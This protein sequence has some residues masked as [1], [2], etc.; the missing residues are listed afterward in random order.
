MLPSVRAQVEFILAK[1]VGEAIAKK[2]CQASNLVLVRGLIDQ[3]KYG[4]TLASQATMYM[5]FWPWRIPAQMTGTTLNAQGFVIHDG[6]APTG[7][8][9]ANSVLLGLYDYRRIRRTATAWAWGKANPRQAVGAILLNRGNTTNAPGTVAAVDIPVRGIGIPWLHPAI[10]G[11]TCSIGIGGVGGASYVHTFASQNGALLAYTFTGHN[12]NCYVRINSGPDAGLYRARTFDGIASPNRIYLSNLDGTHFVAAGGVQTGVSVTVFARVLPY[13]NES[14]GGV[15]PQSQGPV[16]FA[17]SFDPGEN[18]TSYMFRLYYEKSGSPNPA[19][20]AHLKGSYW[21]AVRPYV[22]GGANVTT[23]A[24]DG[25]RG[26]LA[27]SAIGL[28][29]GGLAAGSMSAGFVGGCPGMVLDRT[30]Q[31]L[32]G[33]TDNGTLSS[34]WWWLY[35]TP[36]CL[37][38]AWS[39][40]GTPNDPIAALTGLTGRMRGIDID[41][42]GNVY[43]AL[44]GSASAGI[45][46][47][48]PALAVTRW[49][50]SSLAGATNA[51]NGVKIDKTR[52]RSTAAGTVSTAAGT[53]IQTVTVT[54]GAFTQAD[55]GRAI[56]LSGGSADNGTYKIAAYVSATQVTVSTLAGGNVTFT[57]TSNSG[58]M[59]IGDRIY[60]F[61]NDALAWAGSTTSNIKLAY[62]ETEA[63]GTILQTADCA[64]TASTGRTLYDG[65]ATWRGNAP[66]AAIDP[67][68]GN[69]FWVSS[70]TAQRINR[71]N[72]T[73]RTVS[74]KTVA[75]FTEPADAS[76][77]A[78]PTVCY[79]IG[80]NPH[81]SFREVW[82]ATDVGIIRFSPDH[83]DLSTLTTGAYAYALASNQYRRY[84][85][86]GSST[87]YT[88]PANYAR[89][90][91]C[92][93]SVVGAF[94]GVF[95]GLDGKVYLTH[96][97][98]NGIVQYQ[99]D[100]DFFTR[101]SWQT[102]TAYPGSSSAAQGV[103]ATPYGEVVVMVP[104]VT[105]SV[106]ITIGSMLTDYQWITGA[107]TAK[108]FIRGV[109]PDAT[110]QPEGLCKDLHTTTD[111]LLFG[112]KVA[113]S[114]GIGTDA[115][116]AIGR[117][118][119]K[120]AVQTDGSWS[121]GNFKGSNFTAADVGR[122]LRVE[123]GA[124][125]GIYRVTAYVDA[126]T[127]TVQTLARGAF[128]PAN[129]S[130]NNY[131]LW[132]LGTSAAGAE[133]CTCLAANG[134]AP[135][136]TQD[137]N[138]I[139][140]EFYFAKTVLSDQVE[141]IKVALAGLPPAG[142]AGVTA[143]WDSFP[144][145]VNNV[146]PG[147]PGGL[148]LS[149]NTVSLKEQVLGYVIG[150][151]AQEGTADRGSVLG[152]VSMG[153]V[154]VDTGAG[155]A[156]TVDFG[157][158]VEVGAVVARLKAGA[159]DA[160]SLLNN[161]TTGTGGSLAN[162]HRASAAGGAPVAST[163]VT[164]RRGGLT[165]ASG[166][167]VP[168]TQPPTAT[169]ATGNFLDTASVT[170]SDGQTTQGGNTITSAAGRFTGLTGAV[171]Q[172]TS[173]SDLGY[174]RITS[175]DGTGAIATIRNLA[176]TAKAWAASATGLSFVIYANAAREEDILLSGTHRTTIEML[177]SAT[178]ARLRTY[179]SNALSNAAW[180]VLTPTWSLVKRCEHSVMDSPPDVVN[181]GTYTTTDACEDNVTLGT[182]KYVFDL[183]DLGA[184]Q[185]TGRYWKFTA[186]GRFLTAMA[187]QT[188]LMGVDFYDTAG[189]RLLAN[190]SNYVDTVASEPEFLACH[191]TRLDWIQAL[192]A[193]SAL[194]PGVNATATIGGATGAAVTLAGSVAFTPLRVALGATMTAD[195]GNTF[196]ITGADRPFTA[197][198]VGRIIQSLA[199]SNIGFYRI[200]SVTPTTASVA[201]MD[202]T[203][204]VLT[205]DATPRA[206]SLHEGI[207]AGA[208][209]YDYINLGAYGEFSI[210]AVSNDLKT[211]TLNDPT[212]LSVSGLTWEIRRRAS[213]VAWAASGGTGVDATK[214]AR[215]V[216]SHMEAPRQPGDVSQ[217]H[218]G[219]LLF[220]PLDVGTALQQTGGSTGAGTGTFTGAGFSPDDVGRLLL[221]TGATDTGPYR[222]SA[223][224]NSTTI[225]VVNPRTGAAVSFTGAVGLTYK[226][227]GE[228]RFRISRYATMLRQ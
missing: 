169:L 113:F 42:D 221:I 133:V 121:G 86:D 105:A 150:A 47:I 172:L 225:T 38:E 182:A 93:T 131:T 128:A 173:G 157:T 184:A 175:V 52:N 188:Y 158:D 125:P 107:W 201:L 223:Y 227:V 5:H 82:L 140:T 198:D 186:S 134:I 164:H 124:N 187:T 181:N 115:V 101:A 194:V 153:G 50:Y 94:G 40:S 165:G 196:T 142:S 57:G 7:C 74:Q 210:A 220:H 159:A 137:V 95:F 12:A 228:K 63:F 51:V 117:M 29:G 224:T 222:I 213:P 99:R 199:G 4:M 119:Q 103:L 32:W 138:E 192:Y 146:S 26:D 174:Y 75:G 43:A 48:T 68:T 207:L 132:D 71:F 35:K 185:R 96:A 20:G 15:I 46:K 183:A 212:Y 72:V 106:C 49:L 88:Q 200:V 67:G 126:F 129:S 191:I 77:V 162:L 177:T 33:L 62:M 189:K 59:K 100:L 79:G 130:P 23:I 147:I 139:T 149:A 9:D 25:D 135:D 65:H 127:I 151:P 55:V 2:H 45:Y 19:G 13:F 83:A 180:E 91:G 143:Y 69:L 219:A 226:V 11:G 36:E 179:A 8:Y 160:T 44:G 28:Q 208:S 85:G 61:W 136:N 122:L 104:S 109:I 154:D 21:F 70:D 98:E 76:V 163:T 161:D 144:A 108:E 112:V 60:I 217:D 92:I 218:K 16:S 84:V 80:V 102:G 170:Y 203:T 190:S 211:I 3:L 89:P 152:P 73:S 216:Y 30:N 39:N 156:F 34:L 214:V 148:A 27:A 155:M 145:G 110:S 56:T 178:T 141:A 87:A 18:R 118:S 41:T 114:T 215:L 167:S 116:Q 10:T 205:L 168:L 111:D 202:G 197:A 78:E 37:H 206:W 81:A 97:L 31:R 24:A 123:S 204:P 54:G 193:A 22:Y 17:G 90:A 176:Q 171:V 1:H 209:S 64:V 14:T 66:P 120:Q 58:A 195:A 6:A 53:G 166:L